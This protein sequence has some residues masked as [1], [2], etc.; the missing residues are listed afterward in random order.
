MSNATTSAVRLANQRVL[1]TGAAGQLGSYLRPALLRAG[2]TVVGTGSRPGPGVDLVADV[3][4]R[5]AVRRALVEAAPD[6]VVHGA[7]Y[8]D[9]DGAERDP[10]RAAV[11]NIEGARNVALAA[12]EVGAWL[13]AVS[14]DFVFSGLGGA[15]DAEDAAT[16]PVSVYGRTKRDGEL[17]VLEIDPRFAVART[18]WLYGGAGK[19]FPRTVLA[20][21][22]ARGSIEVVDDEIGSPTFAGDLADALAELAA[23]RPSGIVHLINEGRATRFELAQAVTT[24]VGRLA[25]SVRPTTTTAFLAKYPLPAKRPA[26][27]QLLNQQAAALGIRLRSWREA[28]EAYA[29][30]LAAESGMH[31]D[32]E[33]R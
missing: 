9:V 1:F 18:A 24:A 22:A 32:R 30:R 4:D 31:G 29:P 12:R 10:A 6:L 7:A 16:D 25:E 19:H 11:V 8:T 33:E 26:D 5:D 23:V 13:V 3:T 27:S 2:A 28:V 17:A 14:T 21:I 15:P 20:V